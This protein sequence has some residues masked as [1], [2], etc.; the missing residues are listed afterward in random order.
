MLTDNNLSWPQALLQYCK[1]L[2]SYLRF[3]F[4]SELKKT[5]RIGSTQS[6]GKCESNYLQIFRSNNNKIVNIYDTPIQQMCVFYTVP[7]LLP[8]Y[9]NMTSLLRDG[10]YH[11]VGI[12][13]TLNLIQIEDREDTDG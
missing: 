5:E 10:C 2:G 11:Q 9:L 1:I 8:G 3:S 12:Y 13:K 7:F 6:T 4:C